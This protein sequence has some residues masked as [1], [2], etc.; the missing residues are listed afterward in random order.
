M[1]SILSYHS[2]NFFNQSSED[3]YRE[4]TDKAI[5]KICNSSVFLYK[6]RRIA[7]NLLTLEIV[8]KIKNSS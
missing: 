4:V 6:N 3:I 8:R 5:L 7:I 1:F 2:I